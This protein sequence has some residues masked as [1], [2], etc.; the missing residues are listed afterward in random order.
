M[1]VSHM[2]NLIFVDNSTEAI[3]IKIE[4]E[5]VNFFLPECFC[6]GERCCSDKVHAKII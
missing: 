2:V 1:N 6:V 4:K 5:V 3:G